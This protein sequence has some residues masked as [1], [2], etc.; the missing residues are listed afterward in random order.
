MSDREPLKFEGRYLWHPVPDDDTIDAQF[1]Y[2]PR[3]VF[4]RL[5]GFIP[6]ENP[7]VS[8]MVKAYPNRS[9]AMDALRAALAATPRPER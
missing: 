1:D 4:D 2:L 5:T 7:R 8:L 9:A 6:R 3:G